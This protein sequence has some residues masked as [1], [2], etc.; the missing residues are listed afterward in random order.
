MIE[1]NVECRAA[2]CGRT[3]YLKIDPTPVR[4]SEHQHHETVQ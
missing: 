3:R 1:Y 4:I 2:K